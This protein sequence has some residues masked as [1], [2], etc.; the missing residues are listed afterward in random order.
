MAAEVA[1]LRNREDFIEGERVWVEATYFDD[2]KSSPEN[3]FSATCDKVFG[4]IMSVSSRTC[5]LLFDDGSRSYVS[6][7]K[8]NLV[9]HARII[10]TAVGDNEESDQ[11]GEESDKEEEWRPEEGTSN[12]EDGETEVTITLFLTTIMLYSKLMFVF[13]TSKL[14]LPW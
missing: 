5:Q 9:G 2:P 4:V 1:K 8:L 11:S 12:S 6:K 14:Y 7:E 10:N 13:F 3:R